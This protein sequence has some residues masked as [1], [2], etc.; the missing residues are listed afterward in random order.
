MCRTVCNSS[1]SRNGSVSE[2]DR[3]RY[4]DNDNDT[5]GDEN[6]TRDEDTAGSQEEEILKRLTPTER[7][8]RLEVVCHH[9]PE[10]K[11]QEGREGG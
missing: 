6:F 8:Q 2:V 10:A 9:Q 4:H 1:S 3:N 7:A 11:I 5:A